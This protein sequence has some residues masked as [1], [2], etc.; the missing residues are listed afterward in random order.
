MPITKALHR[1]I[2]L[3]THGHH[4]VRPVMLR[5]DPWKLVALLPAV[6]AAGVNGVAPTPRK[7]QDFHSHEYC[8]P[9]LFAFAMHALWSKAYPRWDQ[10]KGA[11][12]GTVSSFS[13][14][15]LKHWHR[16][17]STAPILV[18]T[19]V[20]CAGVLYFLHTQGQLMLFLI[21]HTIL[22]MWRMVFLC[23]APTGGYAYLIHLT[24]L[25]SCAA[26]EPV[27]SRCKIAPSL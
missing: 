16:T 5:L 2:L 1:P 19:L 12:A 8:F 25:V 21:A 15:L 6:L 27:T 11:Q 13:D 20:H 10:A 4:T 23:I 3:R 14:P 18:L 26:I 22:I 7:D 9:L 17:D 24:F